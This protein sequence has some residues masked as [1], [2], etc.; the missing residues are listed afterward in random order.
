MPLKHQT[1]VFK[2]KIK[3]EY[4]NEELYNLLDNTFT[5]PSEYEYNVFKVTEQYIARPDLISY[6]A[7]GTNI[8]T[9][10]I[11]KLNGISNPFELNTG[12]LLI[13]PTHEYISDFTHNVSDSDKKFNSNKD[14]PIN[15]Q[16]SQKRKANETI[17]GDHRFKINSV[18]GIVIY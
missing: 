11:C 6:D 8:Y 13:L 9:D 4:L 7:Y 5:I 2:E 14:K 10:V 3:S 17:I 16:K 12:T 15:K 18:D 1:L